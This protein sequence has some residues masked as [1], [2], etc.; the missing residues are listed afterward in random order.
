MNTAD[1]ATGGDD[2]DENNNSILLLLFF[3]SRISIFNEES[4]ERKE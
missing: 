4:K 1:N 3:E 2:D